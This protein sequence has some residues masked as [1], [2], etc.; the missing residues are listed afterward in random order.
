MIFSLVTLIILV[1]ICQAFVPI[2][3]PSSLESMNLHMASS[4]RERKEQARTRK[5]E[6]T[7]ERRTKEE[8]LS[9]AQTTA[10]TAKSSSL[11]ESPFSDE[12]YD[13]LNVAIKTISGRM[14]SEES[15]SDQ[16]LSLLEHSVRE[17][18]S[19]A[20]RGSSNAEGDNVYASEFNGK[21]SWDVPGMETMDTEEYFKAVNN[22]IHQL[23][24]K[25]KS[26]GEKI[27]AQ[28]VE[29]YFDHLSKKTKEANKAHGF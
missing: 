27:G 2:K 9:E 16:Q 11:R 17:I 19:D 15:L 5:V 20:A 12:I 25:R 21:S 22:R 7:T 13:H 4:Y 29:G 26:E 6:G 14:K 1:D 18:L 24:N 3:T 23:K 28:A 8:T 10:Q